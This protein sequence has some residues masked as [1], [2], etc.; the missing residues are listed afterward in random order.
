MHVSVIVPLLNEVAEL[1]RLIA[2]LRTV[3]AAEPP[4]S[5]DVM[6]VDGGSTDGTLET[7]PT[8]GLPWIRAARGRAVQ[9]NA[10]AA[11]TRS[12]LLLFLHADTQ[13]ATASLSAI[14][15]AASQG[16]LGGF[17]AVRLHSDSWTHRLI[18]ALICLRSRL[19]RISTGDQ[20]QWLRRD[21]FE[22]LGGFGAMPLFEDIDL[23]LRLRRRGPVAELHPPVVTS[24][25]RWRARGTW[26]TVLRMWGLRLLYR[27]GVPVS[28]LA[29]HYE[30]VR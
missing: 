7:L 18:G 25:R 11:A 22:Q 2:N 4:G 9:M 19:T 26:S 21:A 23:A 20:A 3:L 15:A 6:L 16:A 12:D 14:R 30:D 28:W 13:L 1:P 8:T 27:I 29:R 10:G 24:P 5:V 17:F